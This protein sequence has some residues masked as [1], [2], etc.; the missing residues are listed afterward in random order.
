MEINTQNISQWVKQ[1][2]IAQQKQ[3]VGVLAALP[4]ANNSALGV[5]L[6]NSIYDSKAI[7]PQIL[8]DY[9]ERTGTTPTALGTTATASTSQATTTQAAGDLSTIDLTA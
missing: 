4:Q 5:D 2:Q 3:T 9:W 7:T 1:A 8:R 6:L